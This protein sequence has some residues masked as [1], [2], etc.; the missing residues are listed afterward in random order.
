M[1]HKHEIFQVS[2]YTKKMKLLFYF[3][4]FKI[5]ITIQKNKKQQFLIFF[6]NKNAQYFD[7]CFTLSE[8]K[9]MCVKHKN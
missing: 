9:E 8:I 5:M 7:D 1:N 3:M 4:K 6:F 2:S